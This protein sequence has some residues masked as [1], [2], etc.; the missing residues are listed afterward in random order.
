M[1]VI[2]AVSHLARLLSLTVRL[3]VNM[4]VSE[5]LYV[6]FLGL[7]LALFL[8]AGKLNAVGLYSGA[9]AAAGAGDFHH[10]AHLRGFRAGVRVHDF[11]GHLSVAERWRKGTNRHSLR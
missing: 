2:E 8:F 7:T 9:G 5:M 6:I 1:V 3:W 10:P 4:M 11:A